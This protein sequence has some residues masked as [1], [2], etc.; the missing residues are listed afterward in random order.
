MNIQT[1]IV[2]TLLILSP[3]TGFAHVG[4]HH[5]INEIDIIPMATEHVKMLISKGVEIKDIGKLAPSWGQVPEQNKNF[6]KKKGA[7]IVSFKHANEE[8]TLYLL[9]SSEG[10][11]YEVNY[12]GQF[13]NLG[14]LFG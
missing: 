14:H 12:T 1:I 4:G 7:Y 13:T 8:K 10:H 6:K 11:L 3:I 2:A 9:L 5:E